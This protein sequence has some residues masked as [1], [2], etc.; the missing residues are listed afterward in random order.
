MDHSIQILLLLLFLL[1][2]Y[3]IYKMSNFKL[4]N[5]KGYDININ[6]KPNKIPKISIKQIDN[7]DIDKDN[8]SYEKWNK[9]WLGRNIPIKSCYNNCQGLRTQDYILCSEKC[10]SRD[11][12]GN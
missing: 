4:K 5:E 3:L 9:K 12:F 8:K 7:K 2:C 1:L 11:T 10:L 6:M